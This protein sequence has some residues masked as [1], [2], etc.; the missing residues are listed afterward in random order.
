MVTIAQLV[1]APDCDSGGRGFKSRWSPHLKK[2]KTL[3]LTFTLLLIGT[4]SQ[5]EIGGYETKLVKTIR[6]RGNHIRLPFEESDQLTV[7]VKGDLYGIADDDKIFQK[8]V[9][10]QLY[11]D[12]L[13]VFGRKPSGEWECIDRYARKIL[14]VPF[15]GFHKVVAQN[16][17]KP[18]VLGIKTLHFDGTFD[19]ALIDQGCQIY[20]DFKKIGGKS[21]GEVVIYRANDRLVIHSESEKGEPLSQIYKV[22]GT[23]A[24]GLLKRVRVLKYYPF[25]PVSRTNLGHEVEEFTILTSKI[26]K[27]DTVIAEVFQPL[28]HDGS[29][30]LLPKDAI[31]MSPLY[32]TYGPNDTAHMGWAVVYGK[33]GSHFKLANGPVNAVLAKEPMLKK[34]DGFLHTGEQTGVLIAKNS[35]TKSWEGFYTHFVAEPWLKAPAGTKFSTV[36]DF[37]AG[38]TKFEAEQKAYWS[39]RQDDLEK[40]IA[41]RYTPQ[42]IE[43]ANRDRFEIQI[44]LPTSGG[45]GECFRI[46]DLMGDPQLLARAVKTFGPRDLADIKTLQQA[47]TMPEAELA[48][49]EKAFLDQEEKWRQGAIE[50]AQE[51]DWEE[52][53]KNWD[54]ALAGGAATRASRANM[55]NFQKQQ[56]LRYQQNLNNYNRGAQNWYEKK[57]GN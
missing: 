42:A 4:T 19:G 46:A 35:E 18:L 27:K 53:M 14:P 43:K 26:E 22:D 50:K 13:L 9:Y 20:G 45:K 11:V 16:N 39:K 47:K 51:G 10:N 2:M 56:Q 28:D 36:N 54:A 1:R 17:L 33:G 44:S 37:T 23:P 31:G 3:L 34:Y 48:K 29:P 38:R 52:A 6:P 32:V 25:N 21:V 7:P 24:S 49:M 57:P 12:V 30:L 5:A 40:E 41:A 8:P 55:E 15:V